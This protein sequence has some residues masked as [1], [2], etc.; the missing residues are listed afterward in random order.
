MSAV[1][2]EFVGGEPPR[3]PQAH[4]HRVSN[5]LIL[6]NSEFLIL[7]SSEFRRVAPKTNGPPQTRQPLYHYPIFATITFNFASSPIYVAVTVVSPT[8]SGLI[9]PSLS[10]SIMFVS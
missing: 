7:N 10:I 8:D 3:A 6:L 5:I 2:T 4:R 1:P 9:T